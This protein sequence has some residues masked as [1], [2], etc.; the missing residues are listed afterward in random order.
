MKEK[1]SNNTSSQQKQMVRTDPKMLRIDN[2][3][4]HISR[5]N[6][7]ES[8]VEDNDAGPMCLNCGTA[9]NPLMA[10]IS[11][12]NSNNEKQHTQYLPSCHCIDAECLLGKSPG[13]PSRNSKLQR[14]VDAEINPKQQL[15]F[16]AL[17]RTSCAN[18]CVQAIV[19]GI[20]E[21]RTAE[22]SKILKNCSLVGVIDNIHALIQVGYCIIFH[23]LIYYHFMIYIGWY[24]AYIGGLFKSSFSFVLPNGTVSIRKFKGNKSSKS[25]LY[26]KFYSCGS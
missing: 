20:E 16:K 25:S 13:T 17:R 5:K 23:A 19:D 9:W 21:K 3:F 22:N 12:V 6:V 1:R 4:Q 7:S 15:Q 10:N 18:R 11:T 8:K 2:F 24:Q 26:Q 14:I